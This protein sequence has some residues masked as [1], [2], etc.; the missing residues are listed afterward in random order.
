M[1]DCLKPTAYA[2]TI[3]LC[4]STLYESLPVVLQ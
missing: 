4:D 3:L 2:F 1:L